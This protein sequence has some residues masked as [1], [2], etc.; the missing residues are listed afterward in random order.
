MHF[1][2]KILT[3]WEKAKLIVEFCAYLV[4]REGRRYAV[5]SG[6]VE[7]AKSDSHKFSVTALERCKSN[8]GQ[9]RLHE[10][11]CS[12]IPAAKMI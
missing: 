10:G 11:N 5:A 7:A 2:A 3:A 12:S 1:V 9:N 8:F 4:H 6:K